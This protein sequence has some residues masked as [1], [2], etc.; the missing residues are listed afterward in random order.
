M[1]NTFHFIDFILSTPSFGDCNDRDLVKRMADVWSEFLHL[2]CT[3]Y[4]QT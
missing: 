3:E 2:I 4:V 1:V